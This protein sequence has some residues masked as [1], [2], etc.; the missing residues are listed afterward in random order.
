MTHRRLSAACPRAPPDAGWRDHEP[1]R[2][3]AG[4]WPPDN[5]EMNQVERSLSQLRGKACWGVRRGYGSFLTMEFGKPRLTTRE[6]QSAPADAS[7]RVRRSLARRLVRVHGQWRLWIYCCEWV[8]TKGDVVIGDWSSS[9]RIDRAADFLDGQKLQS[10][11]VRPRG[12]RTRFEFDLGGVLETKPFD[13][14]REQW[15]LY[16]PS[17]K[18][19]SLRADRKFAYG[20]GDNALRSEHWHSLAV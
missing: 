19:L 9:H 1:A 5:T 10:A 12:A 17:G 2:V 20:N 13:R 16:E 4:R 18:V 11:A 8:V 14:T 3:N 7:R 15:L 6:P